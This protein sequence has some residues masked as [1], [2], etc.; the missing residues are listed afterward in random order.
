MVKLHNFQ[1]LQWTLYFN[2]EDVAKEYTIEDS[3]DID[4][5]VVVRVNNSMDKEEVMD[6]V[7]AEA[8]KYF[9]DM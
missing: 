8:D 1:Y 6:A 2:H 4:N 9:T 3:I 7:L 5:V